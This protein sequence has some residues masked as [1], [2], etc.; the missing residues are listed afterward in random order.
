M[1]QETSVQ[2]QVSPTKDSKMVL[3]ALLL[4]T[5][6]HKVWIKGK[7]EQSSEKS[8]V[9]SYTLICNKLNFI[10]FTYIYMCVYIYIYTHTHSHVCVC[11]YIYIYI[12]TFTCACIYIYI[13]THT[14]THIHS[15]AFVQMS[16]V[17]GHRPVDRSSILVDSY[18][19]QKKW[20]LTPPCS[21]LSIIR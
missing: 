8:S 1:A 9:F 16:R 14:Q 18:Q 5:Q 15:Q 21:T 7:V 19:R 13:Y 12:H 3:D 6:H 11:V 10:Y 20:Y 4:N 2:S 17:F